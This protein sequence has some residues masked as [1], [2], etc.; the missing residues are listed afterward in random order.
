MKTSVE[1]DVFPSLTQ[2]LVTFLLSE[3]WVVNSSLLSHPSGQGM[4]EAL[5]PTAGAWLNLSKFIQDTF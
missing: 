5:L 1:G 4:E 2:D 3:H